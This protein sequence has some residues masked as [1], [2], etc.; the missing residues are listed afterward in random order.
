MN[1]LPDKRLNFSGSHSRVSFTGSVPL[2]R[3]NIA[4]VL[5]IFFRVFAVFSKLSPY[6][7]I[8]SVHS[9]TITYLK[10]HFDQANVHVNGSQLSDAILNVLQISYQFHQLTK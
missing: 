1:S 6:R 10:P 8:N 3:K 2:A 4:L 5:I 7:V 9:A